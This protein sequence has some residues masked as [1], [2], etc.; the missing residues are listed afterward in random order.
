MFKHQ[1]KKTKHKDNTKQPRHWSWENLL[2]L[3]VYIQGLDLKVYAA[4]NL[5]KGTKYLV[6]NLPG[7]LHCSTVEN[8]NI[9]IIQRQ[10]NLQGLHNNSLVCWKKR[11][12]NLADMFS[13]IS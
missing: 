6:N 2:V 12:H 5:K 1:S 11:A 4:F 13:D 3:E 7:L 8:K 9:K 10:T